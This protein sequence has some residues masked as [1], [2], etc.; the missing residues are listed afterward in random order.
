MPFSTIFKLAWRNVWRHRTRTFLLMF[1][2]AY[3]ALFS[4]FY[5]GFLDGFG[6]SLIYAQARYILAPVRVANK[7]WLEDPDPQNAL[8]T[9]GF[10]NRLLE[11]NGVRA[12]VP[13]LEFPALLRS[14]YVSEG[15]QVRGV[16]PEA[17][18]QVSK[19]PSKLQT[20]RMLRAA[21]E[22]VLGFELAKRLD[23]RL[24][25]RVVLDASALAGPQA[26]GLRLVGLVNA[27]IPTLDQNLVLIHIIDARALTGTKTA[28]TLE[29]DVARGQE[30][31]VA[32]VVNGVLPSGL[33][34]QGIWE[35]ADVLRKD[36]DA[37]RG[38]G[39][40]LA[41]FFALLAALAVTS[42]V[43]VSVIERTRELGMLQA[44]GLAPGALAFMVTLEAMVAT[45]LG[46]VVG[47]VLGYGLLVWLNTSNIL[48][49]YFI[50]VASG[51]SSFGLTEEIYT[52]I[53]PIYILY[54]LIPVALS[55][56]F[57]VLIPAQRVRQLEPVEAMRAG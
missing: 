50:A 30:S 2:V 49:P 39:M 7:T 1:V 38:S 27:G 19:L 45:A 36:M 28:T 16:V 42:T 15:A 32:K 23:V 11:V 24:G 14:A 47:L 20:G 51:F 3:A 34:A 17:E 9:L 12:V 31:A 52:A 25:E 10:S 41:G 18:A 13:R 26:K 53:R 22:I 43:L 21:G 55:A 54:A 5:W 33:Q 29:L 46:S 56:V 40:F 48:G 37:H 44:L 4:V 6:E 8:L 35:M 57:A